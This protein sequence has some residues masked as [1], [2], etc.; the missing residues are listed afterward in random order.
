MNIFKQLIFLLTISALVFNC[1]ESDSGNMSGSNSSGAPGVSKAGS[2]AAFAVNGQYLY[3]L[4]NNQLLIFS[5]ANPSQVAYTTVVNMPQGI[6]A[7]TLYPY[8][9]YLFIGT[10]QGVLIYNSTNAAEPVFLSMYEHVVSCDP[11]VVNGQYAYVTLRT[12]TRCPGTN[13]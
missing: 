6:T 1:S 2:M 12:G 3:V 4:D 11:V 9:D 8:G 5:I 7:E 10:M 13:Q